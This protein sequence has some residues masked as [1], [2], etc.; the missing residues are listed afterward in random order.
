MTEYGLIGEKLGHS[1]SKEIHEQVAEYTYNLI[2]LNSEE[3]H[4]FMCNA[5]FKGINVTIPYKRQVIKYLDRM[6]HVASDIGAVNC[7]KNI[8]GKLF[9][10]NTDFDGLMALIEHA[11]IDVR[12]K[13]ALILGTGGTSETA[14]AVLK[15]MG[16][17]NIIRVSRTGRDKAVSYEDA[18]S[19][20]SDAQIIVNTTPCGMYPNVDAQAVNLDSFPLAEGVIDVVYNPIRTKLVSQALEKG[21]KAEGGL[22]ML[23]AQAVKASEFFLSMRFNDDVTEKIFKGILARK[24]NIVLTGM[25]ASGK[26]TIGKILAKKMG[27]ELFDTDALIVKK[28]GMT[29]TDIFKKYGEEHFRNL[30][31]EVIKEVSLKSGVIIATGGGAVLK[32]ENIDALKQNGKIFFRNRA[33]EKLVPTGDR[34]TASTKE[35]I[36]KRYEERYPI[37][38]KTC[39]YVV[40]EQDSLEKAAAEILEAL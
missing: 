14:M 34:P 18:A 5:G 13:K 15:N 9:G 27:R 20:H 32:K 6:S 22:Y 35:Q 3:F 12:G 33:V 29:I 8:D 4:E 38:M 40:R 19:L 2:E 36:M 37:Y 30:E 24:T 17:Y 39:D 28:A 26:S 10:H 25:P 21:I 23:V 7:V 1:F 16:A 31:S 11:G